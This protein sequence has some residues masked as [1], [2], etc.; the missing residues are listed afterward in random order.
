[1][2]QNETFSGHGRT[3]TSSYD[4]AYLVDTAQR[5]STSC[6]EMAYLVDTAEP[7]PQVTT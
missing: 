3:S 5:T 2:L 7:Q 4:I 1:M 6:Y